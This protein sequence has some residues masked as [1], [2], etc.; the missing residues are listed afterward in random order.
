[1]K[2]SFQVA[3]PQI[4]SDGTNNW[5]SRYTQGIVRYSLVKTLT[6][7]ARYCIYNDSEVWSVW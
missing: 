2:V 6:G 1:M 5:N 4:V 7:I 3:N